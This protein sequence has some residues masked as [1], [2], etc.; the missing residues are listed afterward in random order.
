MYNIISAKKLVTTKRAEKAARLLR[1]QLV[2]MCAMQCGTGQ[3]CVGMCAT[4]NKS[5]EMVNGVQT[6][7]LALAIDQVTH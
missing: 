3:Y 5:G 1:L 2:P 4:K 7:T 6:F